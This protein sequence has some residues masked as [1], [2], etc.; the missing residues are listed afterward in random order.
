MAGKIPK[1]S[2]VSAENITGPTLNNS[3]PSIRKLLMTS[4]RRSG[5]RVR[6]RSKYRRKKP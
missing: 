1:P 6:R 3:R 2:D 4:R 5:K